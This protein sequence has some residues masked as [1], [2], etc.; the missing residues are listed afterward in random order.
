MLRKLALHLAAQPDGPAVPGPA[1]AVEA[2]QD[3]S[4][5]RVSHFCDLAGDGS[6]EVWWIYG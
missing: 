4:P 1:P 3:E 2:Q 6:D 5:E